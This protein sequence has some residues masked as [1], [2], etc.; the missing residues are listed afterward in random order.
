MM[1]ARAAVFHERRFID[2]AKCYLTREQCLT[3]W[4]E[5]NAEEPPEVSS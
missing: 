3:I 4:A 1:N 2:K 5:V